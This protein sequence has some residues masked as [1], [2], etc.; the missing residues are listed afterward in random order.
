[1]NKPTLEAI[2]LIITKLENE[3]E[4]LGGKHISIRYFETSK[5]EIGLKF[6]SIDTATCRGAMNELEEKYAKH[7]NLVELTETT[8]RYIIPNSN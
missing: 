8:R 6:G 1:M 4:S 2:Q 3:L 5:G 7:L